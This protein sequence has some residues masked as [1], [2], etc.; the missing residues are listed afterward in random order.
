[1][2]RV[3]IKKEPVLTSW[4]D[5]NITLKEIGELELAKEKIEADM[6]LK[7]SDLKLEAE[8]AAKPLIERMEKLASDVKDFVELNRADIKGKT[9][10]LN[11]GKTG[12]RKS[13]KIIIKSVPFPVW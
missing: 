1:M 5:V 6:N 10:N 9:M 12:F 3:R 13:R 2:A 11:F 4:D 8:L 7:I